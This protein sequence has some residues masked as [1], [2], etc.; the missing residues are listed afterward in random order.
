MRL[1]LEFSAVFPLL[2]VFVIHRVPY[3][4]FWL[5]YTAMIVGK[6]SRKTLALRAVIFTSKGSTSRP[7]FP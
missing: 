4:F 5:A 2:L 3:E 1:D 6:G 7:G